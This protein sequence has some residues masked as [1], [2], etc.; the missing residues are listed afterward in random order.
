ML[1]MKLTCGIC[2]KELKNNSEAMICSFECTYC[3]DCGTNSNH[4]CKNCGGEL[5]K[6]PKRDV[7]K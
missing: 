5:V 4:I 2:E 7:R 3:L 1:E 6:R